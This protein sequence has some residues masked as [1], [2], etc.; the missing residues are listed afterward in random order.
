MTTPE[1]K[2]DLKAERAEFDK[3]A[4]RKESDRLRVMAD[5]LRARGWPFPRFFAWL[6]LRGWIR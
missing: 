5:D 3:R 6:F 1:P 2:R 4:P